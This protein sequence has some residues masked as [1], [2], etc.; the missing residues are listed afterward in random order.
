MQDR[1]I[2]REPRFQMRS[3]RGKRSRGVKVSPEGD[4]AENEPGGIVALAAQAEQILVQ[5]MRQLEFTAER[6]MAGLPK[7]YPKKVRR[8]P[9]PLP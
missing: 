9:Q 5:A 4:V 8:G 6:M 2:K 3:G 1:L 7:R